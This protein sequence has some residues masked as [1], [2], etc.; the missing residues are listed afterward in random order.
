MSRQKINE[1]FDTTNGVFK[2]IATKLQFEWFT[3]DD[4]T[5]LD[6]DYLY[7]H[8]GEKSIS[9][10]VIKLKELDSS[11]FLAKLVSII[12]LKFEEKWSRLYLALVGSEYNPIE[13]YDSHEIETPEITNTR[14]INQNIDLTR[15]TD[16]NVYGFNSSSEVPSA[17]NTEHT[18]ADGKDNETSD[19]NVETGTRTIER[20][21]N[22]GV[23]TNQQ[24]ITQEIE[25][26]NRFNLYEIMMQDVDSVLA[27]PIYS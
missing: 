17:S 21:G 18:T 5:T 6:L 3:T 25:M 26:R 19:V 11:T 15:Q 22:I 20:H 8:S 12:A 24:M 16:N 14:T 23:T 2:P 27:L 7:S 1:V 13:N 9:N 10:L 4:A